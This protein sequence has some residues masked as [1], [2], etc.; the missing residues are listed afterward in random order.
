MLVKTP[1]YIMWVN[2]YETSLEIYPSFNLFI[3]ILKAYCI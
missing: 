1:E 3:D 2:I